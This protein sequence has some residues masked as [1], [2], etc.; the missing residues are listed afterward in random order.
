VLL[1]LL[2]LEARDPDATVVILPAGH[3]L[4][5]ERLFGRT[6]WQMAHTAVQSPD[7]VYLLGTEP[8]RVDTELTYVI[9]ADR[10]RTRAARVLGVIER[11]DTARV[12]SLLR[13]GA[14]WDM[15]VI[16]GS[17]RA[18]LALYDRSHG[19][20]VALMR[21]IVRG[22]HRGRPEVAAA[23]SNYR[24]LPSAGFVQELLEP[25]STQL[26]VLRVP[27]CGWSDLGSP[28]RVRE[29]L[30]HL[31]VPTQRFESRLPHTGILSLAHQLARLERAGGRHTSREAEPNAIA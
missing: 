23:A 7:L 14:L 3:H 1:G 15:C 20:S 19:A 13:I 21:G 31:D 9:P 16:A 27:T 17:M 24:R 25:Q 11:P 26:Q 6:L 18:L 29:A 2:E 8:D 5:E 12:R 30:L 10:K 22:K 28:A 4:R